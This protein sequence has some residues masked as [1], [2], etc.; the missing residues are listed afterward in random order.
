M[1][2]PEHTCYCVNQNDNATITH[3]SIQK[4]RATAKELSMGSLQVLVYMHKSV[5]TPLVC[6]YQEQ[7]LVRKNV[8]GAFTYS[9][10]ARNP[11]KLQACYLL[12]N[13]TK[14]THFPIHFYRNAHVLV[15]F[16]MFY[17]I[18]PQLVKSYYRG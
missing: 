6:L 17:D 18:K 9:I 3:H 4:Q 13:G 2:S 16:M 1:H 12:A 10:A 15:F 8:I 14:S 7:I 5:F 11:R